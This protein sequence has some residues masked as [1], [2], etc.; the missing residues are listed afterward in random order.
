MKAFPNVKTP[1]LLNPVG[2]VDFLDVGLAPRLNDLDGKVIGFLDNDKWNADELLAKIEDLLKAKFRLAGTVRTR[3][4]RAAS[5]STSEDMEKL[6]Q[7]DAVVAGI[8]L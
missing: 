5:T 7:C 1:K 8:G 2:E 3:K 6:A 4:L